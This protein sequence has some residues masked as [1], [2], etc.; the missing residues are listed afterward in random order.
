MKPWSII[1][2]AISAIMAPLQAQAANQDD[3][4]FPLSSV[5]AQGIQITQQYAPEVP[6][7][8]PQSDGL[9][10]HVIR[11]AGSEPVLHIS[12][13]LVLD[14][15][16]AHS[17]LHVHLS[18]VPQ[19]GWVVLQAVPL[20]AHLVFDNAE[21]SLFQSPAAE[22]FWNNGQLNVLSAPLY[23]GSV[24]F[25]AVGGGAPTA[26]AIDLAFACPNAPAGRISRLPA[27]LRVV[28]AESS[29]MS[30]VSIT[31]ELGVMKPIPG[32]GANAPQVMLSPGGRVSWSIP[33]D[34]LL[35]VHSVT[36]LSANGVRLHTAGGSS[37]LNAETRIIVQTL[38]VL[39]QP[40][41]T[42]AVEV[43]D[44][45]RTATADITMHDLPLIG[46]PSESGRTQ[47]PQHIQEV[48]M[49]QLGAD[50]P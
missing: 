18:L 47:T 40:P 23:R 27:S 24:V 42:I 32:L 34:S 1:V 25:A 44:H 26:D 33:Q 36:Y 49:D 21:E 22:P 29:R 30:T 17:S 13:G 8:D 7:A 46:K 38:T 28:L 50:K 4:P 16:S 11:N 12:S 9:Q 20:M 5:Q 35:H 37:N 41:A 45:L 10:V 48:P 19:P 14:Q 31:P 15:P 6:E 3:G 39:V 43:Y 2:T